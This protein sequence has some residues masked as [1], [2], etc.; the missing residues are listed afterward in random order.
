MSWYN[1]RVDIAE[2]IGKT[3]SDLY[4]YDDEI[5]F[6]CTTGEVYKMYHEPDC[7][8]SVYIDDICGEIKEI[9][10]ETILEAYEVENHLKLG[11][12]NKYDESY[13]WTFYRIRTMNNTIV[14]R[15]YGTSNG[16]YS[17]SVDFIK[18]KEADPTIP[19][20]A[21]LQTYLEVFDRNQLLKQQVIDWMK[22]QAMQGRV[23]YNRDAPMWEEYDKSIL[24]LD[25]AQEK[26]IPGLRVLLETKSA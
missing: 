7:C 4:V 1:N 6:F 18:L 2:L 20:H 23:C 26:A 24:A 11:P 21:D 10:G 13:T 15:W 22:E 16:Y 8:E 9:V 19:A 12:L 3:I 25:L 14:I 5:Q 17:E